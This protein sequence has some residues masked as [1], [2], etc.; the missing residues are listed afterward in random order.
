MVFDF[1]VN[2]QDKN[3]NFLKG[4]ALFNFFTCLIQESTQK[5]NEESCSTNEMQL[6]QTKLVKYIK[7]Y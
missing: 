4:L 6:W 7:R 3:L 2:Q 5:S 1:W